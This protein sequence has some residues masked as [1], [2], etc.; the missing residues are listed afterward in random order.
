MN[1]WLA[2]LLGPS[3]G[4]GVFF[5][6]RAYRQWSVLGMLARRFEAEADEVERALIFDRR[7]LR[8]AYLR[9]RAR[10][11]NAEQD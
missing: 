4:V 8:E 3:I 9:G 10:I 6:W 11:E 2:F 1:P 5:A 7:E